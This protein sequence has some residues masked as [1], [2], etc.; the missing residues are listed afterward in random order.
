VKPVHPATTLTFEKVPRYKLSAPP[1]PPRQSGAAL[2]ILDI[3][4]VQ[5]RQRR[6][7]VT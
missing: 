3:V 6:E 5:K 7:C 2:I 4:S 1:Q